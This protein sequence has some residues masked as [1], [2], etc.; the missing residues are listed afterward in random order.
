LRRL[1][2]VWTAQLDGVERMSSGRTSVLLVDHQTLFREAVFNALNLEDDVTV[3]GAVELCDD[4]TA[5]VEGHIPDII[6]LDT[7]LP[8]EISASVIRLGQKFDSCRI[9]VLTEHEGPNLLRDLLTLGVSG[10]LTKNITWL[11]LT[12]AIRSVMAR[13]GRVILSIAK[14]SP[15]GVSREVLNV[16]SPREEEVIGKVSQG[17][18]NYQIATRL[19]IAEG[20]VKRHL[21]HIFVKLGAVSR[22]DAVNKYAHQSAGTSRM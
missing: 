13:E 9:I 19:N 8:S 18:S 10:F 22:I 2:F 17:L 11:E 5:V 12:A 16:L 6:L 15:T 4:V 7:A 3:L 1:A 21:Y 20:T 14:A